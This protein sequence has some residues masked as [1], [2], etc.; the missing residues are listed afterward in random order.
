MVYWKPM[1]EEVRTACI[2]RCAKCDE[3]C[4]LYLYY[5]EGKNYCLKCGKE[6]C[7]GAKTGKQRVQMS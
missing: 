1:S 2:T 6:K 5:I 3:E 7:Y 4:G